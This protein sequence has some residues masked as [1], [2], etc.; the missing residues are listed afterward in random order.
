[1]INTKLFSK[2]LKTILFFLLFFLS[3]DAFG[4]IS[5][6]FDEEDFVSETLWNK[7]TSMQKDQ[8]PKIALVL[9]GGGAR[10]FAHIGVLEVLENQDV[11]IDFVVGTSI[12][13]LVGAF[14]CAGIPIEKISKLAQDIGWSTVVD[15]NP[16]SLLALVVSSK[17]ISNRAIEKFVD[18]NIGNITFDQLKIPLICVATDLNTGEIILLREGKVSFAARAS[19]TIPGFLAPVE[20]RQRYLVDGGLSENLPVNVAKAFNPDI[21]IAVSVSADIT[22]NNPSSVLEVLIQAIYIQGS[23][24]D[25]ENQAMA[26]VL[27]TPNVGDATVGDFSRARELIEK[28]VAAA[29]HSMKNIKITIINKTNGRYLFE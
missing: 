2:F 3:I 24:L 1:L 4:D 5:I 21:I 11:P 23:F 15:M 10:G 16:Y 19:S 12:G 29:R 6:P 8:R 13:S 14:Y 27:I 22:K 28:G 25:A 17:M 7:I 26:D 18:E 9:G 20:Y